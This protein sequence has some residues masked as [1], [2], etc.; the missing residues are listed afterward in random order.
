VKKKTNGQFD[1]PEYHL[2]PGK[3]LQPPAQKKK[4][5]KTAVWIV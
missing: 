3:N 1:T 4:E 2:K 5:K